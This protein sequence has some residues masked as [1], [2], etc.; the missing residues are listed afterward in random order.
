MVRYGA[1]P[2]EYHRTEGRS[3]RLVPDPS[4]R[5]DAVPGSVFGNFLEHLSSAIHGG[6]WA[7]EFAN[8]T[9]HRDPNLLPKHVDELLQAGE[10]LSEYFA[11]GFNP[12]VL[13]ANWTPW[14]DPTG[15]GVM[16]LDDARALGIPFPWAPL[17][18]P[19]KVK[20]TV[21]R[22]GGGVRISGG[23][24]PPSGSSQLIL[25][26]GPAGIRQGLFLPVQRVR[27]YHGDVWVR[28]ASACAQVGGEIEIGFRRRTGQ[29][30]RPSG[31]RMAYTRIKVAG[32]E[33]IKIPYQLE[34][35]EGAL[36]PGEPVD[37]YLRWLD[38]TGSNLDLLV[39][40]FFLFPDD[41][42]ENFDPTILELARQWPVPLLR[43]PGGN[44]ASTY[45]WRDGVGPPD[46]RPT[47]KNDAW[48][49]LE[50]NFIGTDEYM[51]LCRLLGAEP[52]I[53]VNTG[54]GTPEEAA[55]WVEYCNGD[56]S[57]PMGRLRAANGHREPYGVKL[58]E[59]GN[60][61]YGAWQGGYFGAEENALRSAEF[62][63]AMRAVDPSI[64]LIAT[65]SSFDFVQPCAAFDH[66]TADRQWHLQLLE[67]AAG[68]VDYLSLHCLPCNDIFLEEASLEQVHQALMG[69]ISTWERHFCPICWHWPVNT[70]RNCLPI[71]LP[72]VLPLQNGPSL[73]SGATCPGRT[74]TAR[75]CMPACS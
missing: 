29:K 71:C 74:R 52:H 47:R 24:M 30:N 60:E 66:T 40:R 61:I 53:T 70:R 64:E 50:Y 1:V 75:C 38:K 28:I 58:W 6:L 3:A 10:R 4:R 18:E 2:T 62:A 49:G 65:G 22:L 8:P 44:F 23:I 14:G 25:D 45:H 27:G 7:Q 43:W 33:W 59:I 72:C 39:D 15:F 46:R 51:Q 35:Q 37:V 73:E 69:Q 56:A 55:A 19:G 63:E 41:R 36:Q 13:P 34:L 26:A 12:E 11:S 31:E 32:S 54:S 5:G 68:K 42:V 9:F 16:A 67:K 17:G 20:A 21:G 57:T 48:Y